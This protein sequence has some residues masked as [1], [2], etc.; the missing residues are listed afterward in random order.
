MTTYE[1]YDKNMTLDRKLVIQSL[2][3]KNLEF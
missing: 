1:I 2:D 3:D